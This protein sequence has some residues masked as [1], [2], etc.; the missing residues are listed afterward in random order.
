MIYFGNLNNEKATL[1]TRQLQPNALRDRRVQA[2]TGRLGT[3]DTSIYLWAYQLSLFAL[4]IIE[5]ETLEKL[6]NFLFISL[7]LHLSM[8]MC[9]RLFSSLIGNFPSITVSLEVY[10]GV[11]GINHLIYG[12]NIV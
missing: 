4:W 1:T 12:C 3:D 5:K 10:V 6:L 11:T 2:M 7:C 9:F 8:N